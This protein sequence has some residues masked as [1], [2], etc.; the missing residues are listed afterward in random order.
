MVASL[1]E[2]N[3]FGEISLLRLDGGKNRFKSYESFPIP[4]SINYCLKIVK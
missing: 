4:L 1:S 2:G 3:Y